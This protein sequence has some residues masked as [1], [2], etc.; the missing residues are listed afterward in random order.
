MRMVIIFSLGINVWN[1]AGQVL[2]WSGISGLEFGVSLYSGYLH[3]MTAGQIVDVRTA[4]IGCR[5][6]NRKDSRRRCVDKLT[7]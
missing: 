3:S 5:G 2:I 4:V 7:S 6:G 1:L